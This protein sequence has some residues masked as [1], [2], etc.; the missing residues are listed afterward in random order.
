MEA[1]KTACELSGWTNSINVEILA[2]A[3]AKAGEYDRAID[4][5]KQAMN[6]EGVTAEER[7]GMLKTLWRYDDYR[8]YR[9]STN[10]PPVKSGAKAA[11][12]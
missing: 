8:L 6:V 1:A 12:Q 10:R 4:Y 3:C 2:A 7:E 5:Q 11:G 9:D